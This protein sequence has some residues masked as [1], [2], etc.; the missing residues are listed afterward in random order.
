MAEK[1][2]RFKGIGGA[3]VKTSETGNGA[4]D[5]SFAAI[6]ACRLLS[7]TVVFDDT[8]TT[9]GDL[10][11]VTMNSEAGSEYDV[12]MYCIDPA[13]VGAYDIIA[14]DAD[15]G[16][17]HLVDGDSIDVAFQNDDRNTYGVQITIEEMM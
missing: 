15:W 2:A 14:S 9:L 7:V 10:L 6:R 17:I 3:I 12:L 16:L 11:T 8:P 1:R 5:V 4:I 13:A